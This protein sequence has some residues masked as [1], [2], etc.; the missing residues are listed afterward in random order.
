MVGIWLVWYVNDSESQGVKP[1]TWKNNH[2]NEG[3]QPQAVLM[4]PKMSV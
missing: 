3:L 2:K 1:V 4:L